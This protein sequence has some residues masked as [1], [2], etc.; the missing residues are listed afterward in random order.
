MFLGWMEPL[1]KA[2]SA[3][4]KPRGRGVLHLFG[5]WRKLERGWFPSRG[6]GEAVGL[7]GCGSACSCSVPVSGWVD[8][9]RCPISHGLLCTH[10]LQ[11]PCQLTWSKDR[12]VLAPSLHELQHLTK[13]ADR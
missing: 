9:N 8:S 7:H 3:E 12:L 4:K 11:V 1:R 13:E 10:T 5:V 6:V 2:L